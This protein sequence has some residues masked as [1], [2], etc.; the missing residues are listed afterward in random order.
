MVS[1]GLVCVDY[2]SLQR[3]SPVVPALPP[4]HQDILAARQDKGRVAPPPPGK[5]LDGGDFPQ[6][7]QGL[8]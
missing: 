6:H 7:I 4:T 1:P 2:A 3:I 5:V 8:H